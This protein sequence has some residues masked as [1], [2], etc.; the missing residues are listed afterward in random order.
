VGGPA[1]ASESQTRNEREKQTK[2]ALSP[3]HLSYFH[4]QECNSKHAECQ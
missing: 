4:S 3:R 2:K 1:Q